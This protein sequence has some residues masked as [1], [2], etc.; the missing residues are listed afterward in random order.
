MTS[1]PLLVPWGRREKAQGPLPTH[2]RQALEAE[3][4]APSREWTGQDLPGGGRA[5]G[6]ASVWSPSR[7]EITV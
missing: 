5:L 2:G 7:A 3:Q 4:R 1:D 6:A